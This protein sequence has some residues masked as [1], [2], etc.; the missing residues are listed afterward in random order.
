VLVMRDRLAAGGLC[1]IV[2]FSLWHL[3]LEDVQTAVEQALRPYR[4]ASFLLGV[5]ELEL[6]AVVAGI[7]AFF[8]IADWSAQHLVGA[9]RPGGF[10]SR[11]P[12][13]DLDGRR[14]REPT[15]RRPAGERRI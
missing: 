2:A 3:L 9:T 11:P 10:G 4:L 1:L 6:L 8:L 12:S 15:K 13:P 14:P 7:A 5:L